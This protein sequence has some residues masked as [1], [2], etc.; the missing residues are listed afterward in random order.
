MVAVTALESAVIC[1]V[2]VLVEI[3]AEL[4]D[5]ADILSS[6][7]YESVNCVNVVL[8]SAC[9]EGIVLVILDIIRR[10]V[11]YSGDTALSEH[12]VAERELALAENEYIQLC[13]EV[14]CCIK[15]G[16]AAACDYNVV[17]FRHK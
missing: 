2:G 11:V 1:A 9:D 14:Y 16:C 12:G 6:F 17:V 15:T 7:A 10:G 4:D 13:G 5:A 3:N 8:E